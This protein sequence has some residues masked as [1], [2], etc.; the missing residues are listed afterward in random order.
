MQV[1]E[2][3]QQTAP[4]A[5]SP[6][7]DEGSEGSTASM[8]FCAWFVISIS[9]YLVFGQ[10]FSF[11]F[12][13]LDDGTYVFRNQMVLAGLTSETFEW[14]WTTFYFSN[15]HPLT[16]LSWQAEVS[17]FS[18]Q[19]DTSGSSPLLEKIAHQFHLTNVIL[20]ALASGLLFEVLLNLTGFRGRSFLVAL[21]FALHPLHVESVVWI[22]ERKDVLSAVFG[23]AALW[24]W[25]QYCRT[26]RWRWYLFTVVLFLCS[27]LS[28]QTLVT[29][30]FLLLLLDVWPLRFRWAQPGSGTGSR[31]QLII[32]KLP[33][34][35]VSLCFCI[36]GM[37]AQ[38]GATGSTAFVYRVGNAIQSYGQYLRQ[39]VLPYGLSI[40]YPHPQE[41]IS[42]VAVAV[43]GGIVVSVFVYSVAQI[44][45]LPWLFVGWSW[46][47][48][49]LVPMIG[50]VQ[51]GIQGAA[52][53]YMYFPI[54]GLLI[55]FVWAIAELLADERHEKLK[56][57]IIAVSCTVSALL[58]WNQTGHWQSWDLLLR[59]A[60]DVNPDDYMTQ[61]T[62]GARLYSAGELDEAEEY[63]RR[64]IVLYPQL[65]D[66]HYNLG[67]IQLRKGAALRQRQRHDE[68]RIQF[69]GALESFS[70]A[71][72][73]FSTRANYHK[74]LGVASAWAGKPKQAISA[75]LTGLR[76]TPT[77]VEMMVN[78]GIA[79]EKNQDLRQAGHWYREALRVSPTDARANQLLSALTRRARAAVESGDEAANHGAGTIS[80]NGDGD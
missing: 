12:V 18:L 37:M 16:W 58:A 47:L 46:F 59:H 6:S 53:R 71:V 52:D 34:L 73:N 9:V 2:Y 56:S 67:M 3:K 36:I 79:H 65:A 44:R 31:R 33:L 8:R 62:I 74:M 61:F 51:V 32:E 1:P 19:A 10:S 26:S 64:A 24:T 63:T 68:A 27:L 54:A 75:Y 23:F 13:D 22:S 45:R 60:E 29:F 39:T 70:S 38:E 78:L 40:F 66:A 5:V 49:T 15:Y 7:P 72:E 43:A 55:V 20:H 41:D 50:L 76:L 17:L 28:K 14:S 21:L 11:P 4:E 80:N 48:G 42:W 35:A 57:A 69:V 25:V 77:D 30:P